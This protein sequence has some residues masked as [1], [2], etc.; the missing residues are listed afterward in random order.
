MT[1][2]IFTAPGYFKR[3]YEILPDHRSGHE[4]YMALE[5]ELMNQYGVELY[6]TYES[7][8]KAKSIYLNGKKNRKKASAV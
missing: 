4:A 2:P 3:F 6:K 8:R 5:L 7:F 1:I